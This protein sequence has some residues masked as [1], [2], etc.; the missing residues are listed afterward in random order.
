MKNI[1]EIANELDKKVREI[2]SYISDQT[3]DSEGRI[4]LHEYHRLVNMAIFYFIRA[5]D[6]EGASI[7]IEEDRP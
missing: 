3:S 7:L 6:Q 2:E 4:T 1:K 5:C